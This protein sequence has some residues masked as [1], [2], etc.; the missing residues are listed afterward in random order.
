MKINMKT[1]TR[2]KA[3]F[4]GLTTLIE[5]IGVKAV[6]GILAALL[7]SK[8]FD[9]AL[10]MPRI[11][12]VI[13]LHRH[14]QNGH[15]RSTTPNSARCSQAVAS[16]FRRLAAVST[17]DQILLSE[18]FLDKAAAV[19]IT[20][21]TNTLVSLISLTGVSKRHGGDDRSRTEPSTSATPTS[22]CEQ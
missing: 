18:G 10:T 21:P 2:K 1:S 22:I 4:R 12:S 13:R 7:I 17:F 8:V 3:Q 6:I 11:N 9:A 20:D 5:M 19:K 14:H 16:G 15:C